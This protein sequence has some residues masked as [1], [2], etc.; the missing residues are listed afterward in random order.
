VETILDET[1]KIVPIQNFA[2]QNIFIA[3][4][5]FGVC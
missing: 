2:G 5:S 4:I 1:Q 3:V